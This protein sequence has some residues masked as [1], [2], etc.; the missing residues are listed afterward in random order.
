MKR[1]KLI[2]VTEVMRNV[3]AILI[4]LATCLSTVAQRDLTPGR[5]R[6]DTFGTRDFRNLNNYGL[7]VSLGPT[8][9]MTP[10][11][12]ATVKMQNDTMRYQYTHDP[13]G[14]LGIFVEIG[15]A[16]FPMK[17]SIF[18]FLKHRLISYY[19]WGLGFKYFGG[20][21]TMTIDITDAQGNINSTVTGSGQY[22]NGYGFGRFT[23]HK[24]FSLGKRHFLDNGLGL[25]VD[26]RIIDGNRDYKDEVL[27]ATQTFHKS[28]VAQVHYELGLGFKLKRGSYLILGAQT[29][30]LGIQEWNGGSPALKWYSSN[31]WPIL[32][33]V[34]YIH[35]FE[36]K[37]KGCNTGSE[38]DRKRN[39]EFMQGQ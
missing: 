17:P 22:Y 25:N 29:P 28:L 8:Y 39:K 1:N 19:D 30:I 38:E 26:Y 27:P 23:L 20:S 5:R 9:M 16:H 24:M 34:K 2:N 14:E 10:Q 13:V 21:E 3:L 12:N 32:F 33:K 37:S 7:Q 6:G 15:T 35:L 11:T 36:K 4:I 31:Y 18:K